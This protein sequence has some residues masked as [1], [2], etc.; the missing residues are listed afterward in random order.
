[1]LE[2]EKIFLR[3]QANL[4]RSCLVYLALL[5]IRGEISNDSLETK[6]D[7]IRDHPLLAYATTNL[8]IHAEKAGHS[9]ILTLPNEQD[10][11]Q[12][13]I[14]QWAQIYQIVDPHNPACPP[15]STT[16]IHMAA[17]ANLVDILERV[18]SNSEDVARKDGDGNTAFHSAARHGHVTAGGILREKAADCEAT[19]RSGRTPLIEAASY[20]HTGFV[21]WLLLQ[22]VKLE[23]TMGGGETALQAA[24]LGGH[25]NVVEIL[26][27]AG[28]SVNA[29]GGQYGNALQAAAHE[30]NSTIVQMLL[31]AGADVNAQGGEYGNALHCAC[32]SG[33]NRIAQMLLE[34]GADV[35]VMAGGN[36]ALSL[37]TKC[38]DS[39]LLELLLASG[40]NVEIA[41]QTLDSVDDQIYLKQHALDYAAAAG[42]QNMV[43]ILISAGAD[44]NYASKSDLRVPLHLAAESGQIDMVTTLLDANADPTKE[45]S[46]S[47][48][49]L[50]YASLGGSTSIAQTLES[51]IGHYN[52]GF[53]FGLC[54]R[55]NTGGLLVHKVQMTKRMSD[56]ILL[57]DILHAYKQRRCQGLRR[58]SLK[59]LQGVKPVKYELIYS[60]PDQPAITEDCVPLSKLL[61]TYAGQSHLC[62]IIMNPPERSKVQR[63][64]VEVIIE[65]LSEEDGFGL[66]CLE[67][68]VV[69]RITVLAVTDRKSVV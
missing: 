35:N 23:A 37:A 39:D 3:C 62:S 66:L 48:N 8:F 54:Y 9:R 36:S 29:K 15:R 26:L 32:S 10:I 56:Y 51:A 67:S 38:R 59:G 20:G 60:D 69:K 43:K 14:G 63:I 49:V 7:L 47:R 17:A 19:N 30:K 1:M 41:L 31:D 27:G 33:H 57:S 4:Y 13:V 5:H 61:T 28:A 16:I 34:H 64:W 58:Y 68:W 2:R 42:N 65:E 53:N 18:S 21:E 6:E 12:Q 40:A 11:L 24:S 22:G 50:Y 55:A 52:K 46:L 45:D 25:Q 44:V